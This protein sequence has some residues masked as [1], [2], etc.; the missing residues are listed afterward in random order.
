MGVEIGQHRNSHRYRVM[1]LLGFPLLT[2]KWGADEELLLLEAIQMYGLGNW[3]SVAEHVGS[4][5]TD[6]R[7]GYL[8]NFLLF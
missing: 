2:E 1:D 3:A 4:K 5:S 6:V 8:F 7:L